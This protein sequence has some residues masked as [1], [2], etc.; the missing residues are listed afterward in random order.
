M[1][2]LDRNQV[3]SNHK[4]VEVVEVAST[5]AQIQKKFLTCFSVEVYSKTIVVDDNSNKVGNKVS[6]IKGEGNNRV[7]GKTN[8]K[9]MKIH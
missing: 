5:M 6:N 9:A 3:N 7:V 8:N 1:I 4:E 2:K